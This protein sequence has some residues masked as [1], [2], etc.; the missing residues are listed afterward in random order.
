MTEIKSALIAYISAPSGHVVNKVLRRLDDQPFQWLYLG[1]NIANRVALERRIGEKGKRV[2]IASLLQEAACDLRQSYIDYIGDL[3]QQCNSLDW[4]G[5]GLSEK[6]PYISRTFLHASY[7]RVCIDV[8]MDYNRCANQVI[9]FFVENRALRHCLIHNLSKYVEKC[10]LFENTGEG[11]KSILL[12]P[13]EMLARRIHFVLSTL[14]RILYAKYIYRIHRQ[15]VVKESLNSKK[16]LTLVFNWIDRRSFISDCDYSDAYL[17]ELVPYAQTQATNVLIVPQVLSTFSYIKAVAGMRRSNEGFLDP[18][19]FLGVT[20][21]LRVAFRTTLDHPRLRQYPPLKGIDISMLIVDDQRKEWM[22]RR[23]S[24]NLLLFRVVYAWKRRGLNIN[25]IVYTYENHTWE[26]ILCSAIRQFYPS[27]RLIAYQH[28]RLPRFLLNYFMSGSEYSIAPL[29]DKIITN[30]S[31]SARLLIESGYPED[32]IIE[33]GAIRQRYLYSQMQDQQTERKVSQSDCPTILVTSSVGQEEASELVYKSVK[34]FESKTRYRV[35]LKCHPLMPFA[36]I[37]R[38]LGL[39]HLPDHITVS[40]QPLGD[41][42][43]EADVLIYTSS[44]T[45]VEAIAAEVPIVHLELESDLDMDPL[46]AMPDLRMSVSSALVLY[47]SVERILKEKDDYV[48]DLREDWC[49]AVR[50]LFGKVT[51]KTY[52]LFLQA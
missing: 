9:I 41:L 19:C 20:D 2:N 30:G 37:S 34:A 36:K 15:S 4:W 21:A 3:S 50:D 12:S 5:R 44:T 16:P 24:M 18:Y 6:N 35:L 43:L 46:D 13:I 51:D 38:G 23:V 11:I 40:N 52:D 48:A 33:G 8:L 10:E 42:L 25:R 45:C 49:K 28:A 47:N 22:R 27:T 1:G 17:G 39:T 26:R 32:L 29:P 7:V 14:L 31:Y